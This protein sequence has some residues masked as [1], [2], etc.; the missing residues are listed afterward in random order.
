[1]FRRARQAFLDDLDS[2][3]LAAVGLRPSPDM[4]STGSRPSAQAD[5]TRDRI[6]QAV[7][8]VLDASGGEDALIDEIAKAA[9]VERR[10][11]F[12][13]FPNKTELLRAFWVWIGARIGPQILPSTLDDLIAMPPPIFDGFDAHE[14]VIRASLHSP[15]G[16]AMRL[17][18]I[19][20]RRQ[21]FA[22]IVETGLADLAPTQRH[23][24]LT[25]THL[26]VSA[27][28][29]ETM[30]DFTG[31]TGLQAGKNR[32]ARL[33]ASDGRP[34]VRAPKYNSNRASQDLKRLPTRPR[35]NETLGTARAGTSL[36]SGSVGR[37]LRPPFGEVERQEL[38]LG[39]DPEL[40]I[41]VAAMDLHRP[42][43]DPQPQRHGFRGMS[44]KDQLHDRRLPVGEVQ[45]LPGLGRH[46]RSDPGTEPGCHT[47]PVKPHQIADQRLDLPQRGQFGI[48]EPAARLPAHQRQ[49]DSRV[50][51]G[52]E[53]ADLFGEPGLHIVGAVVFAGIEAVGGKI[54]HPEQPGAP[55]A[56]R[57]AER[58]EQVRTSLIERNED[59]V[60]GR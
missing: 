24:F 2:P 17:E 8:D 30:K 41:D 43:R 51:D 25:L 19:P 29:W 57:A 33:D 14:N 59:V 15:S 13:Q 44:L 6:L 39:R 38:R 12:R 56:G 18:T 5:A 42:G 9:G 52:N 58:V 22:H 60:E 3:T 20:A 40:A 50:L 31:L 46:G 21:S 23:E 48:A 37:N 10:T 26:M 45:A 1:M 11:V 32:V 54:A 49:H 35:G 55:V 47:A 34:E 28:A 7:A 53:E 4:T 16:R 27:A 36:S